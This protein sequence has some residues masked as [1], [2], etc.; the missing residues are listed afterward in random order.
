MST[1]TK[2]LIVLLSLFSLF[3]CGTIVTYVCT[4][5]NY[6]V[7]YEE[8]E[9]DLAATREKNKGYQQQLADKEHQMNENSSRLESEI[10]DLKAEKTKTE[11]DLKDIQLAKTTLEEKV[12]S[13]T[14]SA[15]E[16]EKT[17]GGMAESLKNTREELDQAR[18]EGVKLSKNLSD[19]TASLEEKM[20]QLQSVDAEKKRLLEEKT[21]LE[22]QLGGKKGAAVTTEPVTT[23]PDSAAKA[24]EMPAATSAALQGAITAVDGP[25]VT[26]SIGSADGVAKDMIFHIIRNDSFICDVK[27]TDVDT[28]TSAGTTQLVQQPPKVGDTASTTW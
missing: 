28:E 25:L 19:I 24:V 27:I 8:L 9:R 11:Q 5:K 3:L 13:L 10:A 6:K 23:V 7:A 20:A 12:Q 22:Q 16:T 21:K 2:I 4:A 18:A 14:S 26:L 1:L 17:V 15:L